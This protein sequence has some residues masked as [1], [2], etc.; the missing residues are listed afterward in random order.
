MVSS[1]FADP[2]KIT[3][4]AEVASALAP[5]L[6]LDKE[7]IVKKLAGSKNF[8]WLARK[9]PPDQASRIEAPGP[10]RHSEKSVV[11]P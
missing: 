8:C 1:V 2:S 4:T 7:T 11:L 3:N 6:N 9:I 5:I 10:V